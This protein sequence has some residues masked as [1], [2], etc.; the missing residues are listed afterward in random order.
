[1]NDRNIQVSAE[2]AVKEKRKKILTQIGFI[3]LAVGL[4]VL[5]VFVL[6]LNMNA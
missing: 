2:T 4:A 1:M 5:T 3:A 6:F